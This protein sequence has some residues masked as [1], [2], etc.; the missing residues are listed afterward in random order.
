MNTTAPLSPAD[1]FIALYEQLQPGPVT[2][3]QLESVYEEREVPH[4][5]TVSSDK[6]ERAPSYVPTTAVVKDELKAVVGDVSPSR[7]EH[8]AVPHIGT[9]DTDKK[10]EE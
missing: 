8:P 6:H 1:R 3:A 9:I 4:I 7:E 5:G 10:E 2:R